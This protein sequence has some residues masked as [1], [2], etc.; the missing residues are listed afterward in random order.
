MANLPMPSNVWAQPESREQGSLFE[1]IHSG[2]TQGAQLR[3][4][5]T[6]GWVYEACGECAD[7]QLRK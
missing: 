1:A 2:K 6:G 3:V 4:Q 7:H 5:K